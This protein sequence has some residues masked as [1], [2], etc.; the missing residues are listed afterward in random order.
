MKQIIVHNFPQI[1]E[2][3]IFNIAINYQSFYFYAISCC[4]FPRGPVSIKMNNVILKHQSLHINKRKHDMICI[5]FVIY[6]LL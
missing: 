3:F 5:I 2:K 6:P 4:R 1:E